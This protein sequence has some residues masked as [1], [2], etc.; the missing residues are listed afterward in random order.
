MEALRRI[1]EFA[2]TH[3]ITLRLLIGP[4]WSDFKRAITNFGA[5]RSALQQ[6]AG[7]H[8]IRDYSDIF[9]DRPTYFNDTLHLNARGADAFAQKLAQDGLL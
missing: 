9:I 6:A 1:C 3:G 2:N 8:E 5:W 7:S 4:C